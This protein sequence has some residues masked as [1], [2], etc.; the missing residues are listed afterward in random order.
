MEQRRYG[1]RKT[2]GLSCQAFKPRKIIELVECIG[3]AAIEK[4]CPRKFA[5]DFGLGYFAL[6]ALD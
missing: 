3:P 5:Y 6:A 2:E 4:W 1:L